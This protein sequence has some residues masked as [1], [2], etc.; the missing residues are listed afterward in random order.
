MQVTVEKW[1]SNVISCCYKSPQ[2]KTLYSFTGAFLQRSS[3]PVYNFRG[4]G[5]FDLL[6]RCQTF[7]VVLNSRF[8]VVEPLAENMLIGALQKRRNP[9]ISLNENQIELML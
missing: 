1:H 4:S 7:S 2:M 8:D 6:S 5:G 3:L 9:K